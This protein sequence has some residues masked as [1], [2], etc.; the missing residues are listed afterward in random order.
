M[1]EAIAAFAVMDAH[2]NPHMIPKYAVVHSF[3]ESSKLQAFGKGKEFASFI[4]LR[5]RYYARRDAIE[6]QTKPVTIA[7]SELADERDC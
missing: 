4:H 5:T 6:V 2:G 3:G 7:A 1:R